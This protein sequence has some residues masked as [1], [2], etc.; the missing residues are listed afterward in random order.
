MG[1]RQAKTSS[2][3]PSDVKA[4]T[5]RLLKARSASNDPQEKRRL[6]EQVFELNRGLALEYASRFWNPTFGDDYN[7]A[8][9]GAL[10]RA[11][12]AFDPSKGVPFHKYAWIHIRR[13]VL[14][15][16]RSCEFSDWPE[17]L[18]LQRQRI[19]HAEEQLDAM[20]DHWSD[21]DVA[22]L[23]GCTVADVVEMREY[24]QGTLP[25]NEL[26]VSDRLDSGL[27]VEN[28]VVQMLEVERGEEA[29]G[30]L[31]HRELFVFIRI[32]GLDGEPPETFAQ[33]GSALGISGESVRQ[34]EEKAKRKLEA[35]R[36]R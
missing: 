19:R 30:T 34:I 31:H 10:H 6:S 26:E 1:Q 14:D 16:V 15:A 8:S 5:R 25:L 35:A 23:A 28:S 22:K 18:F 3:T 13:D 7:A 36:A 12:E 29:L 4:R 27:D 17:R 2:R 20:G 33:V 11:V 24:D 32:H 9:L 21:D